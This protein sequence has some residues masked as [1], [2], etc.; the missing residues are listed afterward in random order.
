[1]FGVKKFQGCHY[2]TVLCCSS[3]ESGR[4]C[5]HLT[6]LSSCSTWNKCQWIVAGAGEGGHFT[7][8]NV[9]AQAGLEP[10]TCQQVFGGSEWTWRKPRKPVYS[11]TNVCFLRLLFSVW[12]TRSGVF[13]ALYVHYCV[14]APYYPPKPNKHL[15]NGTLC[16]QKQKAYIFV[17]SEH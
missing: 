5:Q 1:M 16:Y 2:L 10:T 6:L 8:K 4:H 12:W 7:A 3:L 15:W 14:V 11:P 13:L 17:S 9:S